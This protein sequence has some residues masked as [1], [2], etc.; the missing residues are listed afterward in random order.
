MSGRAY[1]TAPKANRQE[2]CRRLAST[3][4]GHACAQLFPTTP[5]G[6]TLTEEEWKLQVGED[7]TDIFLSRNTHLPSLPVARSQ[8]SAGTELGRAQV[9]ESRLLHQTG[10]GGLFAVWEQPHLF[11]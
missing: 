4:F 3:A 5:C 2:L 8:P 9:E 10:Q 11:P 1:C 6:A 7:V